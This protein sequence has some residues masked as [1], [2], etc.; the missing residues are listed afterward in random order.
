MNT[1]SR[2]LG[3]GWRMVV[4]VMRRAAADPSDQVLAH[5]LVGLR[6]VVA[7]LYAVPPASA[8]GVG[9]AGSV[10]APAAALSPAGG[11]E[12]YHDTLR[13]VL[14]ALRN[15]NHPDD[16]QAAAAVQLLVGLGERLALRQG[17]GPQ[18]DW[19]DD[20][21]DASSASWEALAAAPSA[22]GGGGGALNPTSGSGAAAFAS[23]G[24]GLVPRGSLWADLGPLSERA[25]AAAAAGDDWALLMEVVADSAA[26]GDRPRLAN[27]SLEAAFDVMRCHG[28]LWSRRAWRVM[29]GGV[30]Q[31]V[32][33]RVPPALDPQAHPEAAAEALASGLPLESIASGFVA[34]VERWFPLLSA[35]LATAR[36]VQGPGLHAE[37]L[38]LL[39]ATSL[40]WFRHCVEAVSR[41]GLAAI[42]RLLA[43]LAAAGSSA[44]AAGMAHQTPSSSS[45][46]SEAFGA[47]GWDI[48][49]PLLEAM[50]AQELQLVMAFTSK[51]AAMPRPPPGPLG[52]GALA[53]WR[54]HRI[55]STSAAGSPPPAGDAAA[56]ATAVAAAQLADE[57][58][59]LHCRC[60]MLV[61]LQ[62]TL[63]A[64]LLRD[65]GRLPW[66]VARRMLEQ[67]MIG[68]G[69]K[70]MRFNMREEL[71]L[72]DEVEAAAAGSSPDAG[73]AALLV[74][75]GS[76]ADTGKPQAWTAG[77]G[78]NGW[79]EGWS[80]NDDDDASAA[81]AEGDDG[82]R[83]A[84]SSPGAGAGADGAAEEATTP[85]ANGPAPGFSQ[86]PPSAVKTEASAASI[87]G[88][89]AAPSWLLANV[90]LQLPAGQLELSS[91]TSHDS[92]RPAL[93]RLEVE[94]LDTSLD[95]LLACSRLP[96]PDAAA[97]AEQLLLQTCS[98]VLA[99]HADAQPAA[100]PAHHASAL[101]P[102]DPA[103][104]DP[105]LPGSSW[106][107]AV[108]APVLAR[109]VRLLLVRLPGEAERLA[110]LPQL[111][112]L[113][114]SHQAVV[115][116]AVADYLEALAAPHILQLAEAAEAA[117]A[118][119]AADKQQQAGGGAKRAL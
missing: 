11:H 49:L 16:A 87:G 38:Q 105:S 107:H 92:S 65:A 60:R 95:V 4:E 106:D 12:C 76:G 35:Q 40:A 3:S 78:D 82:A 97:E 58:K 71:R 79:G 42:S 22:G 73:G 18:A 25:A 19:A 1:Y 31:R 77:N 118:A 57:S 44:A 28:R 100:A 17:V 91:A 47:G 5:A 54:G 53:H 114:T 30:L 33:F 85:L 6:S 108:R 26:A 70:V 61:L 110:L 27:A 112:V 14:A 50:L 98:F 41:A 83:A 36:E 23:A 74:P 69:Q 86:D 39:A 117:A 8:A 9:G 10:G 55:S 29:L 24:S 64:A 104:L 90:R 75:E 59:R 111:L 72:P 46:A 113:M 119:A 7:A 43:G 116:Y 96:Q 20:D 52:S 88:G 89:A 56:A 84:A 48:L 99:C 94:P 115:R 62:R 45:P 80:D 68:T 13:A 32:A 93:T 15:A 34:R 51:L 37:L 2:S 63:G 66:P 21:G 101:I 103:A 109:C 67:L 81:A 102:G